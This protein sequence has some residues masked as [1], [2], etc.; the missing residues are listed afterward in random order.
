M[1][2]RELIM[3]DTTSLPGVVPASTRARRADE[4]RR[5]AAQTREPFMKVFRELAERDGENLGQYFR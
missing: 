1:C 2:L 4:A 3:T 5:I